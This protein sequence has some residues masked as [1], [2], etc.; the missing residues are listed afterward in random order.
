MFLN[1][2]KDSSFL[3]AFIDVIS[4]FCMCRFVPLRLILRSPVL[5]SRSRNF[6]AGDGENEP[7]PAPGC[8]CVTYG[9]WGVRLR[10]ATI[11]IILAKLTIVAQIDRKNRYG[12]LK[13]KIIFI[14]FFKTVFCIN[15]WIFFLE[16]DPEPEPIKIG[17]ASQHCCARY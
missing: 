17:P 16:P 4:S 1:K 15:M 3:T 11:L 10:V 14:Y 7:A 12:T 5:S 8:C 2:G 9:F 13:S 6:F